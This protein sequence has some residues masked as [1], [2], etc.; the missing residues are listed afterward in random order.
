MEYYDYIQLVGILILAIGLYLR[1]RLQRTLALLPGM[2]L[3]SIGFGLNE[4]WIG[5][6]LIFV[7]I[8]Y[9][10]YTFFRSRKAIQN[11]KMIEVTCD[12][13]YLHEFLV[14]YKKQLYYFFPLYKSS[15]KD[16]V[17]FLIREMNIAGIFIAKI[18]GDEMLIELDFIK[19]EYRDFKIGNYIY[20]RNTGYFKKMGIRLIKT[21]S[22]NKTYSKYL[23]HMG[24]KQKLIN[25]ELFFVKSID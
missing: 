7:L 23:L 12:D 10:L 20:N 17:F 25:D 15:S 24:F 3:I 18:T 9:V 8:V 14:F 22:Y 16:R 6:L 2:L 4:N 1:T 5:T 13:N 21:K 19:P 11:I